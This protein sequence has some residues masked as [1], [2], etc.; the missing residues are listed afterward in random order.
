MGIVQAAWHEDSILVGA[1]GLQQA[2]RVRAAGATGVYD[3]A[4]KIEACP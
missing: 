3:D 1:D 2:C 4:K